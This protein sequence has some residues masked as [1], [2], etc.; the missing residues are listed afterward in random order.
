MFFAKRAER[1]RER[2]RDANEYK[3]KPGC[4]WIIW[5]SLCT[6]KCISLE[7]KTNPQCKRGSRNIDIH[8]WSHL[9]C[10]KYLFSL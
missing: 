10:K 8:F 6:I 9:Q 7:S 1:E 5:V 3:R 2:E 4:A